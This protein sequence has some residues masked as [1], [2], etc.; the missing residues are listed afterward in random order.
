MPTSAGISLGDNDVLTSTFGTNF[1]KGNHG[2][3]NANRLLYF[4]KYN[5]QFFFVLQP[6]QNYGYNVFDVLAE[7][8]IFLSFNRNDDRYWWISHDQVH[9]ENNS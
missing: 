9:F 5:C 8:N 3:N 4:L 2:V 6:K 1:N 7:K